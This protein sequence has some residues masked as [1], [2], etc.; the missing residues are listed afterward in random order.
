MIEFEPNRHGSARSPDVGLQVWPQ[1]THP[2]SRTTIPHPP[3]TAR[4]VTFLH[5]FRDL[6]ERGMERL[7]A[8]FGRQREPQFVQRTAL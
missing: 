5:V 1:L 3:M 8:S 7:L 2:L 4:A 6:L